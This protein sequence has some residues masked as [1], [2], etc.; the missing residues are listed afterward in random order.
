MFFINISAGLTIIIISLVLWFLYRGKWS[1][2]LK[3]MGSLIQSFSIAIAVGYGLVF[4]SNMGSVQRIAED[5]HYSLVLIFYGVVINI[6]I[7]IYT[8]VANRTA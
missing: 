3:N 5:L 6:L 4:L 2:R 8:R 1:E 7:N